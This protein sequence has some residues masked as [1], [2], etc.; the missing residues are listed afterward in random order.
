MGFQDTIVI[1]GT[2]NNDLSNWIS[3]IITALI[4]VV[5]IYLMVSLFRKEQ[6]DRARERYSLQISLLNS[7]FVELN[8]ISSPYND[9]YI[10]GKHYPTKGN[11]E[12]YEEDILPKYKK[13]KGT[14]PHEV[15]KINTSEYLAKLHN[16][17]DKKDTIELKKLIILINQ[18]LE[19]IRNYFSGGIEVNKIEG[20]IKET[21][22]MVGDAKEVLRKEFNIR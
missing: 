2:S 11:L 16:K 3:V 6:R 7:L 14:P 12:W 15:W 21:K 20:V 10:N 1:T 8:Q 13:N 9:I 22:V 19:L 5:T 18:K 17:V 4:G